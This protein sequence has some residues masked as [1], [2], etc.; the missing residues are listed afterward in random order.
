M[1]NVGGG[2]LRMAHTLEEYL[3]SLH[4][5]VD[6][7]FSKAWPGHR[8][9]IED[10]AARASEIISHHNTRTERVFAVVRD[11]GPVDAWSITTELFGSLSAVHI[12]HGPGEVSA[13]LSHLLDYDL[14]EATEDGYVCLDSET[15]V[16]LALSSV[17]G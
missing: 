7:G 17:C 15:S 2:D 4:H 12:I 11:R 8:T 5:V 9:P 6:R 16:D 3:D 13:H 1:P 10:P 14:V